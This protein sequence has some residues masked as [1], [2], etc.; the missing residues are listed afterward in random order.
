MGFQQANSGM[1]SL[2]RAVMAVDQRLRPPTAGTSP[3][4]RGALEELSGL[5]SKAPLP[6]GA[7]VA[8]S[9]TS[10]AGSAYHALI[11]PVPRRDGVARRAAKRRPRVEDKIAIVGVGAI[12]PGAKDAPSLWRNILG[13]VDAIQDLPLARFD[14]KKFSVHS[15]RRAPS[16]RGWRG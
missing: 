3:L 8:V 15:S 4:R 2:L 1:V 7:L 16:S 9:N 10:A 5:Q 13:K 14:V 12:A 6:E 11:G